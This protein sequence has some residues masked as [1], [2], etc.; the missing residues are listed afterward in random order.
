MSC[1]KQVS[2]MYDVPG[3]PGLGTLGCS[4]GLAGLS[5]WVAAYEVKSSHA[6]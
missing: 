4:V 1:I 2:S 6:C 5:S 3:R